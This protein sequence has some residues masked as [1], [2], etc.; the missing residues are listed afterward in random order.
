DYCCRTIS[1]T[2]AWETP[3]ANGNVRQ[4]RRSKPPRFRPRGT[5]SQLIHAQMAA[6]PDTEGEIFLEKC[7][8]QVM[9][10]VQS[11]EGNRRTLVPSFPNSVWERTAGTS[12]SRVHAVRETEFRT[13]RSKTEFG[14]E[15]KTRNA[16]LLAVFLDGGIPD[17]QQL[18]RV[19]PKSRQLR[20]GRLCLFHS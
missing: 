14:N 9:N 3:L 19:G 13:V 20:I 1:A 2:R 8:W 16:G 7:A 4:L 12:V 15:G 11:R 17:A 6:E 5:G 18:R 10:S